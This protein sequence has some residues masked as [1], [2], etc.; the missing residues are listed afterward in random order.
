MLQTTDNLKTKEVS[1][2]GIYILKVPAKTGHLPMAMYIYAHQYNTTWVI[3]LIV[4]LC[5]QMWLRWMFRLPL[6]FHCTSS[7]PG[8]NI[9]I[10]SPVLACHYS[11]GWILWGFLLCNYVL[12]VIGVG[13]QTHETSVS[14][15]TLRLWISRIKTLNFHKS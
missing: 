4:K 8:Q 10:Y 12:I 13:R 2:C 7:C 5:A 1:E 15:L 6:C 14:Y 9:V 3:V 11:S